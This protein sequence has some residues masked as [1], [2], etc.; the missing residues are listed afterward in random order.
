MQAGAGHLGG[1]KAR[2]SNSLSKLKIKINGKTHIIYGYLEVNRKYV[3][4][5][6]DHVKAVEGD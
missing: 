1:G 6:V 3:A 5:E 4:I 2:S